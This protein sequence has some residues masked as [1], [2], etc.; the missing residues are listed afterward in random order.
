M[1]DFHSR[2][3][4]RWAEIAKYLPGRTDNA[5]KNHWN[6]TLQRK[7]KF[8]RLKIIENKKPSIDENMKSKLRT[9]FNNC[10]NKMLGHFKI[11]SE[12][13]SAVL[14]PVSSINSTPLSINRKDTNNFG[15]KL[16]S[17]FTYHHFVPNRLFVH[18]DQHQNKSRSVQLILNDIQP[19][20]LPSYK[21]IFDSNQVYHQSLAPL[22]FLPNTPVYF[23]RSDVNIFYK[24]QNTN[25]FQSDF[26]L[27][28]N[29]IIRN[30]PQMSNN[31][32]KF[33]QKKSAF[34]PLEMLSN[35]VTTQL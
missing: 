11:S 26:H 3:G 1:I 12:G 20:R 18:Q 29:N 23:K 30:Q 33:K 13:S 21:S 28:N 35:L 19:L 16:P 15:S 25:S 6:S 34:A 32:K 22:T 17:N 24:P 14:T 10:P 7:L 27:K 8:N 4:N 5:I 9:N 2:L 31:L